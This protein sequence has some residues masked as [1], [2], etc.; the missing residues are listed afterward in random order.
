M[1]WQDRKRPQYL[2][3]HD[4]AGLEGPGSPTKATVN[5][6]RAAALAAAISPLRLLC[7]GRFLQ[8]EELFRVGELRD[9][10]LRLRI[11]GDQML[12]RRGDIENRLVDCIANHRAN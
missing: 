4:Q 7:G 8:L 12:L 5:V 11:N 3:A 9:R 1:L 6:R 10:K 2:G